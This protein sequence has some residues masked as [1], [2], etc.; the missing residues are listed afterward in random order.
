[1]R[2]KLALLL[3]LAIFA[4]IYNQQQI[5]KHLN[6]ELAIN[7]FVVSKVDPDKY[8]PGIDFSKPVELYEI[9]EGDKF[10]QYQIPGA[11][12]GNFYALEG[13]TPSELGI[14]DMG[15]DSK[16]ET[17]IKKEKRCYIS[18]INLCALSSY[19]APVVDDWSTPEDETQT[20]GSKLQLFT[21]CKNCFRSC[22]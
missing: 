11:P 13:S 18:I 9:H 12:Q 22:D 8:L 20:E 6:K 3:S 17:T 19:A 5:D 4:V 15:Y 16:S 14:N 2:W 21:T 7:M 1:M 10:I